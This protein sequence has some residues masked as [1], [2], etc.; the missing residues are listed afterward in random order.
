M[1]GIQIDF[2]KTSAG[3]VKFCVFC[4]REVGFEE[5]QVAGDVQV[6]FRG[7]NALERNATFLPY[8]QRAFPTKS[9]AESYIHEGS[10]TACPT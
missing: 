10:S 8:A 9:N 6:L 5:R 4:L 7:E 3:S 2:S 1:K